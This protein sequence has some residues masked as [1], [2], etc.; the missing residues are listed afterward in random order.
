M[1][2]RILAREYCSLDHTKTHSLQHW[3]EIRTQRRSC[4]ID[5]MTWANIAYRFLSLSGC[6]PL[7]VWKSSHEAPD[8]PWW[9][10]H[11]AYSTQGTTPE[12][13]SSSSVQ[14]TYCAMRPERWSTRKTDV[15]LV[16][17]SIK[18]V[19]SAL[20]WPSCRRRC[21][22]ASSHVVLP[23]DVILIALGN[24][25]FVLGSCGG[26]FWMALLFLVHEN[27]RGNFTSMF[28]YFVQLRVR[29]C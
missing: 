15:K 16:G 2:N 8:S 6:S 20:C 4:D 13:G 11:D 1:K 3:I 22:R 29:L 21:L 14:R 7:L 5:D 10:S 12:P 28:L 19:V 27:S 23:F 25:Q 24:V 9:G 17:N 18:R 26:S